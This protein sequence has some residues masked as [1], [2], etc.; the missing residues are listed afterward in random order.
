LNGLGPSGSHFDVRERPGSFAEE[1][2]LPLMG[3]DQSHGTVRPGDSDDEAREAGSRSNIDKRAQFRQALGEKEGFAI[4]TLDGFFESV[5]GR[6]VQDLVPPA[7]KVV[8]V[9][10]SRDLDGRD[11]RAA[12]K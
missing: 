9:F 12:G 11:V 6:Q 7:E 1:N 2:R 10:Q 3:F 8:M 5:D 4:M